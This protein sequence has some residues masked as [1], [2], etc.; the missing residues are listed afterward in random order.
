M[1]YRRWLSVLLL[2]CSILYGCGQKEPPTVNDERIPGPVMVSTDLV[3]YVG[4]SGKEQQI[5]RAD[6]IVRGELWGMSTTTADWQEHNGSW[7]HGPI[8][9]FRFRVLEY[10]KGSGP[11]EIYAVV[12]SNTIVDTEDAAR[13]LLGALQ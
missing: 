9:E 11:D 13:T 10:L 5:L 12:Y 8:L 7:K 6:T 3:P 4:L 2:V 1:T